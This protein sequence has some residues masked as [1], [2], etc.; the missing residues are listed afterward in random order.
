MTRHLRLTP[1][2]A[3]A[4]LLPLTLAAPSADADD[5]APDPVQM[6]QQLIDRVAE[7]EAKL[8]QRDARIAE[9]EQSL[10]ERNPAPSAAPPAAASPPTGSA[11]EAQTQ[12]EALA[13]RDAELRRRQAELDQREAQLEV[14]AGA[15]T[16]GELAEQYDSLVTVKK[17]DRRGRTV[18]SAGPLRF[19]DEPLVGDLFVSAVYSLPGDSPIGTPESVSVFVQGKFTG[20]QFA[21]LESL[22]FDVA[23]EPLEVPVAGYDQIRKRSGIASKRTFDKSDETLTLVVDV[24]TL[25][26]LAEAT[27]LSM[28]T[29][30]GV[31]I[32]ERPQRAL[33]RAL[34]ARMDAPATP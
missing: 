2:L 15:V 21:R 33:L 27:S 14:M 28:R 22:A 24:P 16:T 11:A 32:W 19:D 9:L 5:V 26:R 30:Q 3:L 23:G 13:R 34:L 12:A 18:V 17:D 10:A 29:P 6:V 20:S 1:T 25:R 4:A 8:A 7:L 31:V